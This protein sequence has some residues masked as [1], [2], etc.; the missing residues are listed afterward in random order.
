MKPDVMGLMALSMWTLLPVLAVMTGGVPPLFLTSLV[1]FIGFICFTALQLYRKQNIRAYWGRPLK[2]YM[3]WVFGPGLYT[4]MMLWAIKT[5][6]AFEA[7]ILNYLWP[8]LLVL[9]SSLIN[10]ISLKKEDIIGMVIGFLGIIIL[11]A[12]DVDFFASAE[13]GSGHAVAIGSAI[14]W[15]LYSARAKKGTYPHGFFAPAFLFFSLICLAAHMMFEEP[16]QPIGTE[17]IFVIILGVFRFSYVFWDYAMRFGNVIMLASLSYFLPLISS[18][19]LIVMGL[20][21]SSIGAALGGAFI[22]AGSLI[23]NYK[24]L[25]KMVIRT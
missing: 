24:S 10:K 12:P 11:F 5:A 21:P 7:M 18:L 17:W 15:A 20:G 2:D 6:P 25:K 1:F 4:A 16:N 22:V 3:F 14:V 9:F 8:L 13:F 19:L 23:V